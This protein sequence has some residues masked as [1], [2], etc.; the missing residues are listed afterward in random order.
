MDFA[1]GCLYKGFPSR[2]TIKDCVSNGLMSTELGKLIGT[3]LFFPMNHASICR[4]MMHAFVLD[5]IP[6]NAAFQSALSNDIMTEHPE[7]WS[8]V[9][10][11]IKDGCL[12]R[13]EGN[14]NN[15]KYDL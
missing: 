4:T 7:L 12:L 10:F 5:A 2:Q 11:R 15:N 9:R 3:K 8:G 6:V 13:I 14:L 1:Q